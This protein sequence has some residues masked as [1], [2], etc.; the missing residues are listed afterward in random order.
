MARGDDIEHRLIDY[1]VRIIKVC[2]SLP[3]T[4]A[5]RH[6]ADQL[7]RCGIAPAA[8]YAEARNAESKRDFVHKL[9][10]AL[11]ELNESR[12]WLAILVRSELVSGSRLVP[13]TNECDEICR[14]LN[15]SIHTVIAANN[16][17]N[18]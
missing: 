1:G 5:G 4:S 18:H 15:A 11:K 16:E 10:M 6:L 12:V 14:I 8:M 13:L 3:R 2:E 9:R 7:V 17:N